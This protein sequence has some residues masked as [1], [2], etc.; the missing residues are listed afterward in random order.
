[1]LTIKK[2]ALRGIL[3]GTGILRHPANIKINII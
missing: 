2:R 3:L 1:M